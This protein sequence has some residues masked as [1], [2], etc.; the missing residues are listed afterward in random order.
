MIQ[1]SSPAQAASIVQRHD[2]Q[3]E[4]ELQAELDLA[5]CE[6]GVR[7]HEI[8]RLLVVRGVGCSVYVSRILREGGSFGREA[9]GG[10]GDALVVAV[11]E[12]ERVGREFEP[13]AVAHVDFADQAQVGGGVIGSSESVAAVAG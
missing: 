13:V 9:V 5:G 3:L 12:V 10:Y 11:E 4:N 1:E 2:P 7:L 8:L 6:S